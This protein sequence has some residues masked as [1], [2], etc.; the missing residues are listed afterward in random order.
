M[1]RD[2]LVGLVADHYVP[3]WELCRQIGL[4]SMYDDW[5]SRKE[6]LSFAMLY[7][8]PNDL[9]AL[10]R[11]H[12]RSSIPF[13]P[14]RAQAPPSPLPIKAVAPSKPVSATVSCCHV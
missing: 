7:C 6:L 12:L 2:L 10:V 1:S 14:A 13:P 11:A 3:C 9:G 5:E 4:E 8:D